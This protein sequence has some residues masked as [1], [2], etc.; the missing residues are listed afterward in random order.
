MWPGRRI[1]KNY[2]VYNVSLMVHIR[3]AVSML[4]GLVATAVTSLPAAVSAAQPMMAKQYS[5][6]LLPL[7]NSGV[8]G[9]ATVSLYDKTLTVKFDAMGLQPNMSHDAH[10][11]GMLNGTDA[12]CPTMAQDTNG[13]GY[14]SVFEGAPA[15]GPIKVSLSA[16]ITAPGPNTVAALFA[17]FAGVDSNAFQSADG[18]GMDHYN[19]SITYDL[20]DPEA[21]AAYEG[22]MPLAAQE[23]VIHGAM[24]PESVDTKGGSTTKIVYDELL[25]VACGDLKNAMKGTATDVPAHIMF[26]K[27]VHHQV[28]M[29]DM[30]GMGMPMT[31]PDS[32]ASKDQ[33][34][35]A[36]YE[37]RNMMIDKLNQVG[38]VMARDHFLMMAD[39]A[40]QKFLSMR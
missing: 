9:T 18:Q 32:T 19:Q 15:Y 33:Q 39:E 38:D 25:P 21:K 37:M 2:L 28:G 12:T 13:D 6:Y 31:Q 7:N 36:M 8:S 17:P 27:G 5:V 30:P 4:A 16:P 14:V 23:I 34:V 24:A 10:I 35:G 3:V 20:S 1:T 11:H 29:P 26:G 40:I 22:I